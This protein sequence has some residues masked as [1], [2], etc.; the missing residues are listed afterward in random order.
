MNE[1]EKKV[2]KLL[3]RIDHL[4]ALLAGLAKS[5]AKL[6]E[7]QELFE[8]QAAEARADLLDASADLHLE[9]HYAADPSP[10][11]EPADESYCLLDGTGD[12]WASYDGEGWGLAIYSGRNVFD[13]PAYGL[14]AR[15]RHI[16]AYGVRS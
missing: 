15:E 2:Y 1:N 4:E 14:G 3:G 12:W 6:D 8:R 11:P 10:T 9:L 13:T 5:R 7:E 16:S